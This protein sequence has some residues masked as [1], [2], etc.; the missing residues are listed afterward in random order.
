VGVNSIKGFL[1]FLAQKGED[2]ATE[3][4]KVV[5]IIVD[6]FAGFVVVLVGGGMLSF[7]LNMIWGLFNVSLWIVAPT[8][9]L[10]AKKRE[11]EEKQS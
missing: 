6:V 1:R 3:T 8:A 5:T 2:E 9:I 7:P 4:L 11:D 10:W